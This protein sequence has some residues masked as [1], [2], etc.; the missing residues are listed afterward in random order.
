MY[1]FLS[2]LLFMS[3]S[4]RHVLHQLLMLTVS[5]L[6]RHCLGQQ[7]I[8]NRR[9]GLGQNQGLL[10]VAGHRGDVASHGQTASQPWHEVAAVVWRRQVLWGEEGK[11]NKQSYWR[12]EREIK[13][14]PQTA[15]DPTCFS[16][17]RQTSWTLSLPFPSSSARLH[18]LSWLPTAGQS[19]KHWR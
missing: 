1:L 15:C 14:W 9:P 16:R 10:L 19:S 6:L 8:W 12:R 13:S 4:A 2:F 18:T 5:F 7:G 3:R 11:E 17:F